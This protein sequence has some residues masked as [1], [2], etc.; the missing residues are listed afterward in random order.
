MSVTRLLLAV[1]LIGLCIAGTATAALAATPELTLL[2]RYQP[3]V[4]YQPAEQWPMIDMAHYDALG[5]GVDLN[6]TLWKQAVP[7][8]DWPLR[9]SA[10]SLDLTVCPITGPVGCYQSKLGAVVVSQHDWTA[11]HVFGRA[12]TLSESV[13]LPNGQTVTQV[14]QYWFFYPFDDWQSFTPGGSSRLP[15]YQFH[16]GD[17]EAATIGLT[18]SDAPVFAGYSQHAHGV[19][20]YWSQVPRWNGNTTHPVDHVAYGSHANYFKNEAHPISKYTMG[21]S[22][23]WDAITAFGHRPVYDYTGTSRTSGPGASLPVSLSEIT[24]TWPTWMRFAGGFGQGER[25]SVHGIDVFGYHPPSPAG[26]EY[27]PSHVALWTTPVP[28]VICGYN[29]PVHP[30]GL[31]QGWTTPP[32]GIGEIRRVGGIK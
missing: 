21:N 5:V 24:N 22:T 32:A 23:A 29:G 4:E 3:V 27:T 14:L 17:W 7:V 16:E 25:V 30:A 10:Y 6:G 28:D 2:E 19:W 9:N 18:A 26:P 31:C 15:I 1:M 12:T 20:Q 11:Q 13:A 8:A